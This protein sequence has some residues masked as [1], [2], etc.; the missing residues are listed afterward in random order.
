MSTYTASTTAYQGG[1][2]AIRAILPELESQAQAVSDGLSSARLCDLVA[3]VRQADAIGTD[4]AFTSALTHVRQTLP[5]WLSPDS[6]NTLLGG[7]ERAATE[8]AGYERQLTAAATGLALGDLGYAV[9]RADGDHVTGFEAS[10]GHEK[11]LV[12]V[13]DGGEVVTD[14][15]GLSDAVSC[16]ATQQ[17]FV[18]RLTAYGVVMTEHER[19]DHRDS[20]GGGLVLRSA[21][22]AGRNAAERIVASY[23]SAGGSGGRKPKQHRTARRESA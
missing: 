14:H 6:P 15:L 9:I 17:D 21:R 19:L 23:A 5:A 4:E 2:T 11:L 3:T 18:E 8:L 7:L 1:L 22:A 12:Q 13:G 16:G 20:R 10:R